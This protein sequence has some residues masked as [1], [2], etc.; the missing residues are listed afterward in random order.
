MI[1]C[2]ISYLITEKRWV[3]RKFLL[4]N[5]KKLVL[6]WTYLYVRNVNRKLFH[7]K[8]KE[9][10]G[11]SVGWNFKDLSS[12]LKLYF[13]FKDSFYFSFYVAVLLRTSLLCLQDQILC[14][15]FF[16]FE[17][18]AAVCSQW[19]HKFYLW[20]LGSMLDCWRKSSRGPKRRRSPLRKV[21]WSGNF[22]CKISF[23]LLIAWHV[24]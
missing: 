2:F 11:S 20:V 7:Y 16:I 23:V 22:S 19:L 8:A 18:L 13:I 10:Q 12:F 14:I 9:L 21:I 3:W 24:L 15:K 1:H 5:I 17:Y 6:F 4:W